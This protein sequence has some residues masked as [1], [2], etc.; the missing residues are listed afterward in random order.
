MTSDIAQMYRQ[1]LVH[2]DH[3]KFQII[4]HYHN[5]TIGTFELQRVTFGVSAAPFLATRTVNIL[6]DD[7]RHNF[8]NASTILKRDLY[9]D[10]LLTGTNSLSEILQFRD[11]II[12]LVRKGVSN[13][14]SEPPIINI[15]WITLIKELLTRIVLL[16]MILY[17]KLWVF[18]G[19][20]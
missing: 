9:V 18:F 15:H 10:N 13:S 4:L 1:I 20:L 11:E 14:V 3:H 8:P 2:P 5:D 7:E 19:T 6:A 12:Q 16:T 17:L